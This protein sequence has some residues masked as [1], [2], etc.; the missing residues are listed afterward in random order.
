MN[1]FS[2]ESFNISS[3]FLFFYLILY[4]TQQTFAKEKFDLNNM[5]SLLELLKRSK[6]PPFWHGPPFAPVF[7]WFGMSCDVL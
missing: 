1:G 4:I 6:L 2:A 5:Q 3:K 7:P